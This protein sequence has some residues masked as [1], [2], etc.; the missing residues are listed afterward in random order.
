MRVV[1]CQQARFC[2]LGVVIPA[3]FDVRAR[4]ARRPPHGIEAEHL[5]RV[6]LRIRVRARARV[7]VRFR[8]RV[9]GRVRVRVRVRVGVRVRVRV[10]RGH[11][12]RVRERVRAALGIRGLDQ[13][14]V[15]HKVRAPAKRHLVQRHRRHRRLRH[16]RRLRRLRHLHLRLRVLRHRLGPPAVRFVGVVGR[17]QPPPTARRP[18]GAR[19]G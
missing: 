9:R 11:P 18:G 17:T 16:L 5:V 15:A 10:R 19:L 4:A 12:V 8:I 13:H 14:R 2:L 1:P 6:R 3:P 7:G